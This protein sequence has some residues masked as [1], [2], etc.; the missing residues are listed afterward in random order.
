MSTP[1]FPPVTDADLAVMRQQLGRPMR[2]VV[3]IAARC[4]C[5]NPTVVATAPRLPDGTPFPTFYYLTH[6]AATAALSV[7]EADHV[8]PDLAAELED[9][10]TAAA[11]RAAHEAYLA[12][13]AGYGDVE[14]IAGISAGGMPTRVKC[15]HA[16]AGHALAAGPGVNPIGDRALALSTWS[17]SRCVCAEPGAAG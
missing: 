9:E 12:D 3:G 2:G 10:E 8:M 15:L 4:V 17:P 13:R 16:L 14:E 7:L 1:P 5:G 11:Y 6:P